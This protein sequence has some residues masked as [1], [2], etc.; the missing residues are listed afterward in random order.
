METE[1]MKQCPYCTEMVKA[2]ASR[3]RYCG[4]ALEK[5]D[6]GGYAHDGRYWRKVREGKKVAGVCTGLAGQFDLPILILPLRAA[7]IVT[8]FLGMFGLILYILLWLLMPAPD[9]KGETV[10]GNDA[11]MLGNTGVPYGSAGVPTGGVA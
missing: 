6:S 4:S 3:C 2:E 5:A 10:P 7:F 11:S 8:T 1:E 9:R